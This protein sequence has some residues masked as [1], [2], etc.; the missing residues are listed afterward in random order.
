MLA[1]LLEFNCTSKIVEYEGLIQGLKK[2]LDLQVK[3]IEVFGDSQI[4]IQHVRNS[5]HCISNHLK[6]YQ[7]KVWDLMHKFESFNIRSIPHLLNMKRTC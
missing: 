5:I 6:N 7:R 1:C 4:V 3:C 2:A